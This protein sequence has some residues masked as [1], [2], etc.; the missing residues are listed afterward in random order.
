MRMRLWLPLWIG[1][2]G[3]NLHAAAIQ[4]QV[5]PLGG[6]SFRYTY[7][8]SGFMFQANQALDIQFNPSLYGTLSNGM[9]GS[10]FSLVLLQP[11]NPPG[12]SGDYIALAKVTNP[13][14]T[15]P[16]NIDFL[17]K[18]A[19]PPGPGAQPY[20]VEQIDPQTGN[21]VPC[22]G[23]ACGSGTTTPVGS[24]TVPEPGSFSLGGVALLMGAWWTGRRRLHGTAQR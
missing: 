9:V 17:F 12:T 4:F 23:S 13:P 3:T 7:F 22:M 6:T 14:L 21:I 15:G 1:L 11:N 20:V 19:I 24:S 16:F 10:G 2:L 5:T 8:L 18:G